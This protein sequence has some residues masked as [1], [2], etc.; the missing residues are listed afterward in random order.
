MNV[1]GLFILLGIMF[2][3]GLF[4]GVYIA[5]RKK[6]SWWSEKFIGFVRRNTSVG[7]S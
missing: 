4:C 7:N 6:K 2:L 3:L 5:L 1:L